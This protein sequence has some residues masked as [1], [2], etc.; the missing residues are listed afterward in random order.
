[1]WAEQITVKGVGAVV[2]I[3]ER[4]M[5]LY[6]HL[7][8]LRVPFHFKVGQGG[9]GETD[10]AKLFRID[11]CAVSCGNDGVRVEKKVR[12]VYPRRQVGDAPRP[13]DATIG[14]RYRS[15]HAALAFEK[16]IAGFRDV[17]F[18]AERLIRHG[19]K[20]F[21]KTREHAARHKSP[22]KVDS[23]WIG[24]VQ[25]IQIE[26]GNRKEDRAIINST[27]HFGAIEVNDTPGLGIQP[28]VGGDPLFAR[29]VVCSADVQRSSRLGR[30]AEA[31]LRR[32]G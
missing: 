32:Y 10:I 4:L 6:P 8:Q 7:V 12:R 24:I 30:T 22:L 11:L 31:A 16:L 20:F 25:T 27:Q 19:S 18:E 23:R 17:V 21:F 13:T 28:R 1:A 3:K 2:H 29:L 15:R 5:I 26:R 9:M 14:K